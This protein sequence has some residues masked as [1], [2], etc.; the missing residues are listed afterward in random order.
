MAKC[1]VRRTPLRLLLWFKLKP[2]V[3]G[4]DPDL[5]RSLDPGSE[6]GSRRAKMTHKKLFEVLDVLF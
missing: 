1:T 5:I 4:P 2:I 3:L 6:S